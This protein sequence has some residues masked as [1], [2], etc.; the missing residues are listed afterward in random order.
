MA[1]TFP[2][3]KIFRSLKKKNNSKINLLV[4][5]FGGHREVEKELIA[6]ANVK[7]EVGKQCF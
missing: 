1:K 5:C 2:G 3:L 7:D 4:F 6:L